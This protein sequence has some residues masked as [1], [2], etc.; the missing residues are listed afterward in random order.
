MRGVEG[1]GLIVGGEDFSG[2]GSYHND[3]PDG[4]SLAPNGIPELHFCQ[5]LGV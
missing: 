4:R 3:A 2:L 5:G 1:G